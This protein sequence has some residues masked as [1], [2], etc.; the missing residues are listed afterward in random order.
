MLQ[1]RAGRPSWVLEPESA[2]RAL[3]SATEFV[4]GALSVI[5]HDSMLIS[6]FPQE[7]TSTLRW[8]AFLPER[9]RDEFAREAVDMLKACAAVGRYTAFATFIED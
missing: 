3:E 4:A 9:D 1:Q 8:V 7:L 2:S 5:A 6:R